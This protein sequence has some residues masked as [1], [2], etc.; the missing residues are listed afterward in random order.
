MRIWHLDDNEGMQYW[1]SLGPLLKLLDSI[2][3]DVV[4]PGLESY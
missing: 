3:E 4:E 1:D 2:I